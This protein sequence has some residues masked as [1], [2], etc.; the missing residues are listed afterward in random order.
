[1]AQIH[2]NFFSYSLGYATDIEVILPSFTANDM[3]GKHT[4]AL[5]GRFPV[6]YLLHGY[7]NDYRAW[8]RYTS[9]ERYAEEHRI[10]VVTFSC[11]NKAYHNA[12]L[13]ENFYDF[14]N[15][16]LPEFVENYFPISDRPENRYVAGLSMG[17][18]G[19]L[20]HGIENP[21]RY[22]AIGAFSPGIPEEGAKGEP[23]RIM[24]TNLFK[25]AREAIAGGKKL[26][27]LFLCI[28]EKDFLYDRVTRFDKEFGDQWTG[29]RYRFDDLPSYD[30][31]FAFWD[32]EVLAFIEWIRRDDAFA[33]MDK[34]KV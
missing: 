2:C 25:L 32:K 14:L 15:S 24:R 10:A 23:E 28:G 1:M 22:S 27:D 13:G 20:L 17:G 7:A 29:D 12:P 21:Q 30:H 9:L 11:H 34:N 26:P 3:D 33:A 6:I 5:P 4:H 31:E 18:Y 16:E 8:L 19:A